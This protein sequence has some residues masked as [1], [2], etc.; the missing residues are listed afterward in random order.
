MA[1]PEL[2]T[3]LS[4]DPLGRGY[5]QYIPDCPGILQNMLN[6]QIYQ[7]YKS[8]FVTARTVLAEVPGGAEILDKLEAAAQSN[9]AVK[10]AMKFITSDGIDIGFSVTHQLLDSLSGTVLTQQEVT[11]LKNLSL[12]SASR[13]EVLGLT[14][15]VTEQQ[16]RNAIGMN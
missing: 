3:E 16:V 15:Y 11:N 1:I 7:K 14:E 10:W 9:S 12:Q 13:A 8:R 2:Q 5:A 6:E 4:T